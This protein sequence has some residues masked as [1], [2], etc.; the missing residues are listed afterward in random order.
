MRNQAICLALAI[1]LVCPF[2]S[3]QWVHTNLP[4]S[5]PVTSFAVNGT[6]LYAGI[7]GAGVFL[8]TDNGTK[9]TPVNT[10]LTNSNVQCLAAM[11]TNLFA[12][13]GDYFLGSAYIAGAVFLSTNNGTSWTLDTAGMGVSGNVPSLVASGTNVFAGT[14]GGLFLSTD[15][16]TS[17]KAVNTGLTNP[18]IRAL[19]VS[20][21]NLLAGGYGISLSTNSGTSWTVVHTGIGLAPFSALVFSGTNIFAGYKPDRPLIS[22]RGLLL[23]TNSGASWAPVDSGMLRHPSPF[24]QALALSGTNLFAGTTGGV[25]LSTNNGTSWNAVNTGLTDTLVFSLAVSGT[26]LFAGTA[27]GVWRRLLSDMIP[28]SVSTA[29]DE[30]PSTYGLEQN[31]PNPF[32]PST[33]IKY[34]LPKA[35]MVRLSVYDILGR[36]VSVLVNDRR[37]AGA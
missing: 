1:V 31:Y 29:A 37:N 26:N 34:E 11:G 23:S 12:G 17:W 4:D 28:N 14:L 24:V 18:S 2:A 36:Q 15:S 9:W 3:A 21:T 35:S 13:T 30:L 19:A 10:D 20:G 8:S 22:D 32:N 33:T 7:Q 5:L 27:S 16:G 6:N 25:F